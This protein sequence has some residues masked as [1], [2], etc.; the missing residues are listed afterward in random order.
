MTHTTARDTNSSKKTTIK[1]SDIQNR[2]L[3]T[4][5]PV[6]SFNQPRSRFSRT[7]AGS[8][9]RTRFAFASRGS[10]GLFSVR[11]LRRIDVGDDELSAASVTSR[12]SSPTFCSFSIDS[13]HH[14]TMTSGDVTTT[15][16]TTRA[17]HV[18]FKVWRHYLPVYCCLPTSPY[19]M[20][21]RSRLLMVTSWESPN[22]FCRNFVAYNTE[23]N[24]IKTTKSISP[25]LK[26]KKNG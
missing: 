12:A 9:N 11:R 7:C 2:K 22:K 25:H 18:N 23:R 13:K 5:S 14:M 1:T 19:M 10:S 8:V 24:N 6:F 17:H 4:F 26:I 20:V 15:T 3:N 16:T 21:N